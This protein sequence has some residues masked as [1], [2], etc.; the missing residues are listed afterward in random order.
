MEEGVSYLLVVERYLSFKYLYLS[1]LISI[2]V[3][4]RRNQ[5]RVL[6]SRSSR[7]REMD[8]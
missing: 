6:L 1:I 2:Y 8:T 5:E 3:S 4:G 7:P